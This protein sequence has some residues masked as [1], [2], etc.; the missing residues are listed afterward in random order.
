M[1]RSSSCRQFDNGG[2]VHVLQHLQH[3]LWRLSDEPFEDDSVRPSYSSSHF[4]HC[5]SWVNLLAEERGRAAFIERERVERRSWLCE[6]CSA[7][8][9]QSKP[10]K[11]LPPPLTPIPAIYSLKTPPSASSSSSLQ[12]LCRRRTG[13]THRHTGRRGARR[14]IIHRRMKDCRDECVQ[15]GSAP[16]HHTSTVKVYI[17]T[18]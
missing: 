8:W 10:P 7:T 15:S 4:K 5:Q 16:N 11:T 18:S 2:L 17:C 1:C 14:P 6:N 3:H 13:F 9:R 12:E